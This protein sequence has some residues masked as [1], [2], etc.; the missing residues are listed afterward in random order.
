VYLSDRVL[1]L[2]ARPG[3]VI[4]EIRVELRRPRALTVKRT[5]ACLEYMDRIWSVRSDEVQ[6]TTER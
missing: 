5:P 4:D 1:V 2:G 3:R 6:R